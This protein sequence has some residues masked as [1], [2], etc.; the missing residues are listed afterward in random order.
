MIGA[1]IWAAVTVATERQIGW[2]AV[3]VGVLVGFAVRYAGRG[4]SPAF[5]LVG[6][7]FALFGCVLGNLFS[8][9]GFISIQESVPY[10]DMLG[11]VDPATA[12]ELIRVTFSPMD[13]L[14][15]AIAIYEGYKFS[16]VKPDAGVG[17]ASP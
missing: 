17:N 6:A 5:G 4:S 14:F 9:V 15:Y 10:F 11:R 3:G 13:L 12:A 7:G 1:G 16:L 8:V 2:M